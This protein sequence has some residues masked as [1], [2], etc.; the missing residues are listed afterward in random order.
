MLLHWHQT[1]A[2]DCRMLWYECHSWDNE[3]DPS[4]AVHKWWK[5]KESQDSRQYS[6]VATA[7]SPAPHALRKWPTHWCSLWQCTPSQDPVNLLGMEGSSINPTSSSSQYVAAVDHHYTILIF[8]L[9]CSDNTKLIFVCLFFNKY[10]SFRSLNKYFLTINLQLN[11][12]MR[13]YGAPQMCSL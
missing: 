2:L 11:M 1:L 4:K 9:A 10:K 12:V 6:T 13:V 7:R 8:I 5:S 3:L